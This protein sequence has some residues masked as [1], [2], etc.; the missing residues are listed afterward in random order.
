MNAEKLKQL[1]RAFVFSQK[2]FYLSYF[3]LAS[4]FHDRTLNNKIKHG[5]ERALQIAYKGW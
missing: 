5:H 2:L 4:M 3:P 1:M